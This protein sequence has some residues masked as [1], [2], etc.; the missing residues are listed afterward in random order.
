MTDKTIRGISRYIQ[1][2]D[3][4]LDGLWPD[5]D[6]RSEINA[7]EF[8]IFSQNGEDGM[9]L[10]LISKVKAPSRTFVEFGIGGGRECNTANLVLNFGWRG[11]MMD[12]SASN[13]KNARMFF[14]YLMPY[15]A[16]AA[17]DIRHEF[18]TRENIN[19]LIAS[20]VA[21]KNADILSIDID[22][23]DYWV[24]E[25][26]ECITPRIVVM[27][28]NSTYGPT[29]S[30]TTPYDPAFDTYAEDRLGLYHGASL[31]ALVK[32]G[33]RKGYAF[34]GCDSFGANAFFVKNEFA[35]DL[36]PTSPEN[37]FYENQHKNK[38]GSVEDQFDLIKGR[39]FVE[40]P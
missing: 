28:Y 33:Q 12:G 17:L 8:K 29:R 30:L 14:K 20:S 24:W 31:S 9:L 13:V 19:S 6:Q 36:T 22:G 3:P 5:V 26:I 10:W 40:I 39:T 32:L 38:R 16:Y 11:L 35:G 18:V 15:S 4:A 1:K 23:N 7:H 27:E 21:A 37:A 2:H 25:A 34:V